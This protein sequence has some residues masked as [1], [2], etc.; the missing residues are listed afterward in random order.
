MLGDGTERRAGKVEFTDVAERLEE[1]EEL[2]LGP[3]LQGALGAEGDGVE[4]LAV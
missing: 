1:G 2:E 4:V 3:R